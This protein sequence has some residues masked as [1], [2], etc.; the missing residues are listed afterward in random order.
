LTGAELTERIWL[1]VGFIG[2]LVFGLRFLVQWIS[3]EIK[4]ESHIPIIFWYFS[5]SGGMII[6]AYAIHLKNPVFIFG[7]SMG[8]IVY[9]RNLRLIYK[10][11]KEDRKN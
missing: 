3:S 9:L 2:Q 7:Q 6:L 10:K 11:E 4:K 1:A 8:L 5:I